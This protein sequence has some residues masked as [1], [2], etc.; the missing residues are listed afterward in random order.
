MRLMIAMTALWSA[1]V[2]LWASLPRSEGDTLSR[3]ISSAAERTVVLLGGPGWE[4]ME[5]GT[6]RRCASIDEALQAV[7]DAVE[8]N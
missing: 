2:F 1:A 8:R 3:V 5:V 7:R 6:A 4:R